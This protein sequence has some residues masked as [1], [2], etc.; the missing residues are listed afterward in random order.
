MGKCT[1]IRA[2]LLSVARTNKPEYQASVKH[3]MFHCFFLFGY[4]WPHQTNHVAFVTICTDY[5]VLSLSAVLTTNECRI[6]MAH[7]LRLPAEQN[8]Q[9]SLCMTVIGL[10]V[11]PSSTVSP[12]RGV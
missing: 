5:Q 9:L 1:Y 4:I 7:K 12:S 11:G 10:R 6:L 8:T 3:T 2:R